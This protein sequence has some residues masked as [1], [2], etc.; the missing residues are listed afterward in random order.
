VL[1][2]AGLWLFHQLKESSHVLACVEAGL[3]DCLPI[4][5]WPTNRIK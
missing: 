5:R 4:D 2:V 3:R 1:V